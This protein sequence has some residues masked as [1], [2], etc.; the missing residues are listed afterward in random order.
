MYYL[1]Y[2][3]FSLSVI[4]PMSDLKEALSQRVWTEFLSF[5]PLAPIRDTYIT[6]LNFVLEWYNEEI[7]G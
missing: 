6:V 5:L 1:T 7:L 3:N 4:L 2:F